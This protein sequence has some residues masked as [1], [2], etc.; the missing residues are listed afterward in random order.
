ML[1]YIAFFAHVCYNKNMDTFKPH[2]KPLNYDYLFDPVP[3]SAER[4]AEYYCHMHNDYEMLFFFD[5]S[6]DYI[7]E[8]QLYHLSKNTLLIIKPM[9]YHGINIISSQPYERSVFYFSKLA[10]SESHRHIID[11]VHP[12][13]HIQEH[14]PL[15]N[16][17]DNLRACEK[18]FDQEEFEYLKTSSLYNILSNLN[19]LPPEKQYS[20]LDQDGALLDR[21]IKF[22][23]S[24]P[25]RVL[26]T[27]VLSDLFFVSKSW[28][29]HK[30]KTIL[31]ISPKQYINQK[32]ILYAQSLI[33]S[34]VPILE[35]SERCNYTNYTTF[36]RQYKS[37][38]NHKPIQDQPIFPH[39]STK[40]EKND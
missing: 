7:I 12:V 5:G 11:K 13:Y 10:L 20:P 19:H 38:L 18:I 39:S 40:K 15:H 8:N 28:I 6:A 16:I 22:I 24:N 14:T 25:E 26:N 33:L 4:K 32:K 17:F 30:F 3:T 34:G 2:T 27:Q 37:F 9:V 36:Y 35:V 23:H 1:I 29:D 31:K 21:I